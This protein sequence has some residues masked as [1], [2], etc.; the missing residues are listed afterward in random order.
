MELDLQVLTAPR[1][2]SVVRGVE[3]DTRQEENRPQEALR[4]ANGVCYSALRRLPRRDFHPL[5]KDSVMRTILHPP[6]SRRTTTGYSDQGRFQRP[7]SRSAEFWHTTGAA[8]DVL[9]PY[10]LRRCP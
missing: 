3:I 8:A 7:I 1:E 4:L 6:S 2:S 10:C 5:D 9:R